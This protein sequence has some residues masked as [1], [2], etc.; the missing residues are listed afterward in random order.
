MPRTA[1]SLSLPMLALLAALAPG[2]AALPA[3]AGE[4]PLAVRPVRHAPAPAPEPPAGGLIAPGICPHDAPGCTFERVFGTS[5]DDKAYGVLA[6]DDGGL[7]AVGNTR[8]SND[9]D[10]DAWM[11]RF[12]PR[13]A[14]VWERGFRGRDADQA[15]GV[16]QT[17]DGGIVMAG[18]TRSRGQGASDGWAVKLSPA[19]ET[20]WQ[21]TYGGPGNDRVR[22]LAALPGGGVALAGFTAS[23]PQGDRDVWVLRL[24]DAGAVQWQRRFGGPGLDSAF[25]VA[26]LP[27]GGLAVAGQL[28]A[29]DDRGLSLWV[30][31][32]APDGALHWEATA[33]LARFGAATAVAAHPDGGVA[34]AGAAGVDG[35]LSDDLWLARYAD[36]GAALWTRRLGG[37]GRDTPWGLGVTAAGDLQVAAISW[38][39]GRGG[40]DAWILG[41]DGADGAVLWERRYGGAAWDRPTGLLPLPTGPLVFGHTS[42]SG[43][44]YEDAWLL[45]LDPEGRL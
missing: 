16:A 35:T 38:S 8:R 20:L 17:A 21:R 10:Y 28:W 39:G 23:T 14:V 44:G 34:V 42:S 24:D 6:L 1:L 9:T 15:Y 27:E 40:G 3:A 7:V 30:L 13:G 11:V 22:G 41:V 4:G 37:A 26:A 18:H 33:D 29:G 43:A 25:S 12:S 2:P 5:Q 31:R 36:D 45:K 32:L 19:G